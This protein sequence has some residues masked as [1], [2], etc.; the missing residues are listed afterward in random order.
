[1][2][3]EL[4][5]R[6]GSLTS[7]G[8]CPHCATI[9]NPAQKAARKTDASGVYKVLILA[10]AEILFV[11]LGLVVHLHFRSHRPVRPL[12]ARLWQQAPRQYPLHKGPVA[13]IGELKGKGRIYLIQIG[14]HHDPYNLQSFADWL[15]TKY[16]LDVRVL[17]PMPLN[18]ADWNASRRQYAA[19]LVYNRL[20]E[21][22]PNLIA[23]PNAYLIGF[24]DADIYPVYHDWPSTFA[25][26]DVPN[27]TAI[28]SS[29]G[30]QD[31]VPLV[32]KADANLVASQL[33]AKLRRIL[34]KYVA[35]LYWHLPV[36][37]D[38]TSV[39]HQPLD[40]S[41]PAEDI[42]A[43]DLDPART[44]WG[45]SV[46]FP[47]LFFLYSPSKSIQP[48]AGP[49]IHSCADVQ[50]PL[51]STST[52]L[53]IVDLREGSISSEHTEFD[54]PGPL[55]LQFQR[56]IGQQWKCPVS[57][58]ISGSNN[59]DDFL[60]SQDHLHNIDV[61]R[62]G[63]GIGS[64]VR[65]KAGF[66][67]SL[68]RDKW[69]DTYYSGRAYELRWSA[70][71]HE[72]FDLTR[73][74]GLV[75]SFLPCDNRALCLEN[76]LRNAQGQQILF[77]RDNLRRLTRLTSPGRGWISLT[78][79]GPAKNIIE[80][81]DNQGHTI[82]Y[83]YDTHV[84]LTSVT[85]PSGEVLTYTYD[86]AQHLLTFSAA[87]NAR[88]APRLLMSN[89]YNHGRLI[90]QTFAGDRTYTYTYNPPDANTP[91]TVVVNAPDSIYDISV[92]NDRAI[93]R[94]RMNQPGP[95]GKT[96]SVKTPVRLPHPAS[97]L[98]SAKTP[99]PSRVG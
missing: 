69:V 17:P 92:G 96:A 38:P 90:S 1:M 64:L 11:V 48:L 72:H 57:F 87:P 97:K 98:P 31:F 52:E 66:F 86:D 42:F 59:Y 56:S 58:G 55:P 7:N 32:K 35:I 39:L 84:Q 83:G 68:A 22:H 36:N 82:R 76:G 53:F 54:I 81:T 99:Q 47:C 61:A 18:S 77:E 41:I 51:P 74:D 24:T 23:D 60:W 45:Q 63:W 93:V 33:Q 70:G 29:E 28:I 9:A 65:V 71:P 10:A 43:S 4:C 88:T 95:V 75:E 14:P 12:N 85:Y 73:F 49:V 67:S 40:P 26:R 94:E 2:Q 46:G 19:E 27:R 50:G 20:E 8:V 16:S 3:P 15:H 91:R 79:A 21:E 13:K 30:L 80:I 89:T 37:D 6:C 44:A 5:P 25:E 62:T 34:L 78:Y